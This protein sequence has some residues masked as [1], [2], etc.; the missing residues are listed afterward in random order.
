[1]P[2]RKDMDCLE[3][4]AVFRIPIPVLTVPRVANLQLEMILILDMSVVCY[5]RLCIAQNSKTHMHVSLTKVTFNECIV[6]PAVLV[7]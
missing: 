2:F 6:D 5:I 1:M 7:F 4:G 3:S